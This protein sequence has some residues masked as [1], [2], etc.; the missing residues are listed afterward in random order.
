MSFDPG[1][2]VILE[3]GVGRF[4]NECSSLVQDHVMNWSVEC[5]NSECKILLKGEGI[6]HLS[7]LVHP[8][9][10]SYRGLPSSPQFC[11]T[12]QSLSQGSQSY[13]WLQEYERL[14]DIG[15]IA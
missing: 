14:L 15:P 1:K 9:P 4:W 13:S 8:L 10:R 2:W 7:I 11:I 5:Q 12:L 3:E 6:D